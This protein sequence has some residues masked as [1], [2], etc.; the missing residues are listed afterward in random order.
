MAFLSEAIDSEE[1]LP[2]WHL[3]DHIRVQFPEH[4]TTNANANL[5]TRITTGQGTQ[6]KED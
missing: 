2:N 6:E 4:L 3:L 1:A 5:T